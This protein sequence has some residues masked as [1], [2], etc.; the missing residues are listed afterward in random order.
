VVRFCHS[1][2]DLIADKSPRV[3]SHVFER[4]GVFP[5]LRLPA[6]IRDMVY[7]YVFYATSHVVLTWV[8]SMTLELRPII[9]PRPMKPP[10]ER[11]NLSL[12]YV[13]R[14]LH[15]E[16]ALLPYKHTV[17]LFPVMKYLYDQLRVVRLFLSKRSR[18]QI[19]VLSD[20]R[21]HYY[22]M[23]EEWLEKSGNGAYWMENSWN[24]PEGDLFKIDMNDLYLGPSSES[25]AKSNEDSF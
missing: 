5:F 6:E 4:S 17:F 2:I 25:E 18:A 11:P 3:K 13:S 8:P 10:M 15:H 9:L 1:I 14:Q 12:L 16:T 20:L 23:D 21:F 24:I 22:S 19:E 7:Y